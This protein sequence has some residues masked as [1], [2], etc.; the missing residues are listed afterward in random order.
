MLPYI[1]AGIWGWTTI[2]V[3]FITSF[4]FL[5]IEGASQEVECPFH[6]DRPNHLSM[7]AFCLVLMTNIQQI[8]QHGADR[9]IQKR[10]ATESERT[11][12]IITPARKDA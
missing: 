1:W 7:D 8:M 3:V 10:R 12:T 2:P 9:E 4:A 11:T 5:G 6:K